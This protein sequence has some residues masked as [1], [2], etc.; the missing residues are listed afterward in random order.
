MTFDAPSR[1]ACIVRES[2]T[3]TPLQALALMNDADLRRGRPGLAQRSHGRSRCARR[4][5]RAGDVPA[6]D[7]AAADGEVSW[8]ILSTAAVHRIA[9]SDERTAAANLQAMILLASTIL[10]L[11]AAVMS[12]DERT[13]SILWTLT[14][15]KIEFG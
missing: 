4:E 8:P 14:A 9:T 10:N 13:A 11:D 5:D 6:V 1:E 12:A 15:T 2:R 3:N 7:G